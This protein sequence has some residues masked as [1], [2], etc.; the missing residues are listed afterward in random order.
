MVVTREE[1]GGGRTKGLKGEIYGD[2]RRL[3]FGW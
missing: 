2:V 1:G 3:D